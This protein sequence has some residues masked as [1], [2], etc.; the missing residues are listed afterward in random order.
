M[1][2]K[3][4]RP[5]DFPTRY[6]VRVHSIS[7]NVRKDKKFE[8]V[9][10]P[11]TKQKGVRE[12]VTDRNGNNIRYSSK[13]VTDIEQAKSYVLNKFNIFKTRKKTT[14]F[15]F[16]VQA[17]K[18]KHHISKR[19]ILL[20]KK[21]LSFQAVR[22]GNIKKGKSKIFASNEFDRVDRVLSESLKSPSWYQIYFSPS[23]RRKRM[24]KELKSSKEKLI[25]AK[26][27]STSKIRRKHIQNKIDKI[28]RS[29]KLMTRRKIGNKKRKVK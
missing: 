1:A 9:S 10:F 4:K 22:S 8:S 15:N 17:F 3:K 21:T 6:Y 20:D 28:D 23:K 18:G 24:I 7:H 14:D 2:K 27:D 11:K 25:A 29:L 26:R 12:T 13:I 19:K 16:S 5:L